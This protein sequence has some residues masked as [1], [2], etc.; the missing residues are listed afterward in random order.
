MNTNK[1]KSFAVTVSQ[2]SV[3]FSTDT[4][5]FTAL[6]DI[7]LNIQEGEFVSIIGPS[8]C[9]KTTLLR[10]IGALQVPTS[11]TITVAGKTAEQAR[12][13][14]EIAFV[15]QTPALLEW[16]DAISNIALPMELQNKPKKSSR[17]RAKELLKSMGLKGFENH[18]P[19]EL[20]GGM[21]QRV[22]IARALSVEP[23]ILLM[24]E[25]FGA[26]DE[27]MRDRLNVELLDIW[28]KWETTILFV[29]HNIR[30]AVFLSDRVIVLKPH[31]GRI[32]EEIKVD[33]PHNSERKECPEY[34]ELCMK[35]EMLMEA[36]VKAAEKE[37]AYGEE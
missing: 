27:I 36:G 7:N 2:V 29:T 25:P 19:R 20:S 14:R 17:I 24:D 23:S 3:D 22:S 32:L 15:F 37:G 21:Q 33:L 6:S 16:R 12:L 31:P 18:F 10:S 11:G 4:K 8:G 13:D 35:G 9:G 28:K 5:I 26:L 34:N 30:E 1:D